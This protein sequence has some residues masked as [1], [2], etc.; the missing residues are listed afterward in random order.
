MGSQAP[1]VNFLP[2]AYEWRFPK[3]MPD[4]QRNQDVAAVY[5][6]AHQY[7][8]TKA[9]LL[10][11]EFGWHDADGTEKSLLR[12]ETEFEDHYSIDSTIVKAGIHL[13]RSFDDLQDVNAPTYGTGAFPTPR[14]MKVQRPEKSSSDLYIAAVQPLAD[15]FYMMQCIA[16]GMFVLKC[17]DEDTNV[18]DMTTTIR[19]L[20]RPSWLE[21]NEDAL[22]GVFG[23]KGFARLLEASRS[24]VETTTNAYASDDEHDYPCDDGDYD[25]WGDYDSDREKDYTACDKECGYCGRCDY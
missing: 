9:S 14:Y 23:E 20:P 19:T 16:P 3:G 24:S 6:R 5:G 11:S 8:L 2:Y 4:V 10:K 25:R 22:V 1:H 18:G 7:F 15:A 12:V 21:E 13:P 17:V